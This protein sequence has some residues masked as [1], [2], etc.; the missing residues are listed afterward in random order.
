MLREPAIILYT[1]INKAPV[2]LM[3]RS[4][5]KNK[6]LPRKLNLVLGRKDYPKLEGDL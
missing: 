6:L 3:P 4:M 1:G 5:F 2:G